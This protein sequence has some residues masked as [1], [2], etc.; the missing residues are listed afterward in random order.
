MLKKLLLVLL[1]FSLSSCATLF[2]SGKESVLSVESD[3]PLKISVISDDGLKTTRKTPFTVEQL[4]LVPA[5]VL[6]LLVV[7][8]FGGG[9]EPTVAC[10]AALS[11]IVAVGQL[12]RWLGEWEERG[13]VIA[14]RALGLG[15]GRRLVGQLGPEL[16]RRSS[17]L[18]ASLLPSVLLLESAL[19]FVV[20]SPGDGRTFPLYRIGEVIASGR[21][22][23]FEA[24]WLVF[25]PGLVLGA[26]L[27]G[28]AGLAWSVRRSI[29]RPLES[30][31]F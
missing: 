15:K 1:V 29:D 14:A 22:S 10:L 19:A 4:Q 25:Y 31:W 7:S 26:L 2:G 23:Q 13:D 3:K 24:P 28:L 18:V 8:R 20:G 6:G 27:L 11:G 30:R 5:V 12:G 9:V 17:G 21:S 16:A